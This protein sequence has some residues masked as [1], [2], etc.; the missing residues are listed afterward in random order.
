MNSF[1]T[2]ILYTGW[3]CGFMETFLPAESN[4]SFRDHLKGFFNYY[5]NFDYKTNVACP[6][7]GKI[8]KKSTFAQL[9][10]LPK[11]MDIYLQRIESHDLEMFRFD[12]AMCIQDPIDHSQNMTKA[13]KKRHLRCFRQYCAEGA[14]KI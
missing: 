7:L 1:F 2:F 10:R 4:L 14:L 8:I 9:D 13:V 3:E 12:S 5:A 6:Y 11:E